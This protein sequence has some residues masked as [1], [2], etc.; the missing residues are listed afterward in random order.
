MFASWPGASASLSGSNSVS[1]F[2]VKAAGREPS[3]VS[4]SGSAGTWETTD[5]RLVEM[6]EFE[7]GG[8]RRPEGANQA[9]VVGLMKRL[10][11]V[12]LTLFCCL[13]LMLAT[14]R[15]AMAYVDPGS[16]LLAVQSIGSMLAAAGFFLRRRIMRLFHKEQ[17]V[18]SADSPQVAK[19]E[20]S[21][22][23]A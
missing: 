8:E 5:V 13:S 10:M 4:Y 7:R 14:E 11:A 6:L 23:A 18:S 20:D 15:R 2:V 12:T 16:G 22:N 9:G 1:Y 21:R 19:R 17:P 3:L